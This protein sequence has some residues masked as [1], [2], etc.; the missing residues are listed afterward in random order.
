[1]RQYDYHR[2]NEYINTIYNNNNNITHSNQDPNQN[3]NILTIQNN[4][5]H[6]NPKNWINNISQIL[7]NWKKGIGWY[8][9]IFRNVAAY[10]HNYFASSGGGGYGLEI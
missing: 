2:N 10:Y 9:I 4:R 6:Y 7:F 5:K 3:S 8:F 1:M